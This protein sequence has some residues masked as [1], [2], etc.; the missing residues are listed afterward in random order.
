VKILVTGGAGFIAS[1]V[2]DRLIEEGHQV[3][4][5]DNLSTGFKRNIHSEALFYEIDIR[6]YD[7]LSK[8][9]DEFK[10]DI[11][12][13]HAGQMDVRVSTREPGID[14]E[15]NIL[16]SLNVILLS[17]EYHI[18]KF[19]Y[20]STGG[21]VYGE[22]QS[23]P[24]SEEHPINPLS[25]YG[26]S[27]HTVEH[28]L[29]LYNHNY[30]LP[31]TVLRYPNVFGPRQNPHGE[32]GVIAIFGSKIIEGTRP[33]IFGDG[34]QT[35]DYVYISDVV[36]ANMKAMFS[37][38]CGIYNI[39]SGIGTSVLELHNW[40]S[41]ALGAEIEPIFEPKRLGE[42]QHICLDAKRAKNELKWKA[43]MSVRDGIARTM[44][45][46]KENGN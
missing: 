33:A 27:K 31:Y 18:R 6:D 15:I 44:E 40:I 21:A 25:Q 29:Y 24:V 16:G 39:G 1:H 17:V 46:L 45:W 35:R 14:A 28:Y 41:A 23:L 32:A 43:T 2:V 5:V 13:H 42:I 9:F 11:V 30:A 37:D 3:A 38:V 20:I 19:I 26:I 7:G 4:V 8:V 12:N 22:P 36:E 10:P 34:L